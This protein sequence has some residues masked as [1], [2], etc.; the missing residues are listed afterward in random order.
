MNS[1]PRLI[2]A[3]LFLVLPLINA[4]AQQLQC[5]PCSHGYGRVQVNTTKQYSFQLTNTGTQTL[6]ILSKSKKGAA[7]SFGNFPLPVTLKPGNSV[8]LPSKFTPKAQGKTT[9]T[10]TLTTDAANPKLTI[11]VWGTGIN[12]NSPTLGVSPASL[13][14]GTVTVGNQLSLPLTLSASNGAVTISSVN[15]SA[16][17]F[18]VVGLTL[19]LTIASG[20]SVAITV[21][22]LPQLAGTASGTLTLTSDAGNSPT[23]VGLTGTGIVPGAHS[24]DLS[25]QASNDPVVG[26]NIYRGTTRG[27]PY[28]KINDVLDASTAYTDNGVQAGATYFYVVS[29]VDA[30][31]QESVYS[32][33]VKVVIPTP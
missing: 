25:W 18:S 14:F 28:G 29:A 26:Y 17:E 16:S 21:V 7:F 2:L 31:S 27:G 5:S 13:D 6:H 8:M 32:N 3:F 12:A 1:F 9:G 24:T 30:Q 22:F 33:E 15:V 20:Q 11:D 10:I 4:G 23:S 19:P